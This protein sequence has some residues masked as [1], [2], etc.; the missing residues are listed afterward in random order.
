MSR[1]CYLLTIH[2]KNES[3]VVFTLLCVKTF[4]KD[5]NDCYKKQSQKKIKKE[6]NSELPHI[7]H[8]LVDCIE[9]MSPK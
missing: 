8:L 4:N 2:S 3:D 6:L 1:C 7:D 9:E 5:I